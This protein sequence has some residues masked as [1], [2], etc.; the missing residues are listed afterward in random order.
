MSTRHAAGMTATRRQEISIFALSTQMSTAVGNLESTL[1]AQTATHA[2][3]LAAVTV[4]GGAAISALRE[5]VNA[6]SGDESPIA[7]GVQAI[8]NGMQAQ[9]TNLLVGATENTQRL[10]AMEAVVT[11]AGVTMER[12]G[13]ALAASVSSS[14][15]AMEDVVDARIST[16]MGTLSDTSAEL[17]RSQ[18]AGAAALTASVLNQI[19]RVNTSL[20]TVTTALTNKRDMRL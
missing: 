17:T 16:V 15:G 13:A 1:A 14:I 8:A 5:T 18:S 3:N 4:G 12:Q 19:R 20:A 9:A 10:V 6:L 2:S 7:L 11:A